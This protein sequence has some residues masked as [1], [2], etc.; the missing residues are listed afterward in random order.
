VPVILSPVQQ[1]S[2]DTAAGEA[3]QNILVPI[4]STTYGESLLRKQRAV[5]ITQTSFSFLD[6]ILRDVDGHAIALTDYGVSA[7]ETSSSSSSETSTGTVKA[8]FREAS[9]LQP[10]TTFTSI[11]EVL[12]PDAGQV[13][14]EIPELLAAFPGVYMA[15]IGVFDS[16]DRML[17]TNECYILVESSSWGDVT[18]LGPPRLQDVRMSLRDSDFLENELIDNLDFD[19][20]EMCYAMTRVVNYWNDQPPPILTANFTT[21]NFPFR[22][23]WIDGIRVFLFQLAE[24]HYRRNF[25]T[26]SAGGTSVDD[27]NRFR[28]YNAA[29]KDAFDS[30]RKKLIHQKVQLNARNAFGTLRSGYSVYRIS[31]I[32]GG[33]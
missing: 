18:K 12:D 1:P 16:S 21:N 11:V 9:L 22:D 15:E 26:H 33:V 2:A 8:C 4:I 23:I 30:F 5:K 6:L 10:N 31:S 32:N 17:F 25:F 27:K 29:M 13:K 3:A 19:L 20:A 24:E 28:E 7:G 14:V